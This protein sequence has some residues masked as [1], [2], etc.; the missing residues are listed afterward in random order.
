MCLEIS[1][2]V[3]GVIIVSENHVSLCIVVCSSC[4]LFLT[5][6]DMLVAVYRI[7]A[8]CIW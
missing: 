4:M 6:L 1:L 8:K 7:R 2:F 3:Y 5:A